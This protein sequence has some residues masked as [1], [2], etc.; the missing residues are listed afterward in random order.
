M[1]PLPN[2]GLSPTSREPVS[3]RDPAGALEARP[4]RSHSHAPRAPEPPRARL[5]V[6]PS[7][8]LPPPP[9][10]RPGTLAGP[11][12]ER[13]RHLSCCRC[14]KRS[15]ASAEGG[16]P[17]PS[18]TA[19][20]LLGP[21]C[22]PRRQ[23]AGSGPREP[24]WAP[25]E[26][27]CRSRLGPAAAPEPER[28]C[29]ALRSR[30][31]RPPGC[32]WPG[33]S[34][35]AGAGPREVSPGPGQGAGAERREPG[36]EARGRGQASG[37]WVGRWRPCAR[38]AGAGEARFRLG[39]RTGALAARIAP[40]SGWWLHGSGGNVRT[41]GRI[42]PPLGSARR[43]GLHSWGGMPCACVVCSD[44]CIRPGVHARFLVYAYI[45]NHS[46][47]SLPRSRLSATAASD[48]ASAPL[49][50]LLS[51]VLPTS[52]FKGAEAETFGSPTFHPKVKS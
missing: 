17:R 36:G 27:P 41:G 46:P 18:V 6:A 32:C 38:V 45:R 4:P 35:A 13:R 7:P 40:A 19:A 3:R 16:R 34:A 39:R 37:S 25:H 42:G 14:L 24:R 22:S 30:W 10:P 12:R 31:P 51:R 26:R 2:P 44:A 15:A 52:V 21:R 8:P 43:L 11:E 48:A 5:A 33:C 23:A 9:R 29:A 47:A 1:Q 28:C 20:V 50:R 49:F